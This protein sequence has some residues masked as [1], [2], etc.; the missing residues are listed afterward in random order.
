MIKLL[1]DPLSWSNFN[2]EN[3]NILY[4]TQSDFEKN[5]GNVLI[6]STSNLNGIIILDFSKEDSDAEYLDYIPIYKNQFYIFDKKILP[7]ELILIINEEESYCEFKHRFFNDIEILSNLF[8]SYGRLFTINDC[9]KTYLMFSQE[10]E[11][12]SEE[13]K[14]Y[15]YY[16]Q[17]Y[18]DAQVFFGR[19]Y[20]YNNE[21]ESLLNPKY[22]YESL[23]L[24]DAD[25]EFYLKIICSKPSYTFNIF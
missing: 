9:G 10:N 19:M 6:T 24:F 2:F 12:P 13:E 25:E 7:D 8:D 16:R 21:I 17:V 22:F 5:N 15:I 1:K 20:E 23:S 11:N 18:G 4:L 3:E 14:S